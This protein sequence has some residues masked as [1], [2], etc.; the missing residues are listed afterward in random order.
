MSGIRCIRGLSTYAEGESL[1][2][3]PLLLLPSRMHR[4]A[5]PRDY[6][7]GG[8]H[9]VPGFPLAGV[10]LDEA[11]A[12]GYSSPSFFNFDPVARARQRDLTSRVGLRP[13][14]TPGV[15]RSP[16]SYTGSAS[17]V[18]E[19]SIY[20]DVRRQIALDD[21]YS[22]QL[23]GFLRTQESDRLRDV[24]PAKAD[25]KM[26]LVESIQPKLDGR[27]AE[28]NRKYEGLSDEMQMQTQRT[29]QID[30]R[31]LEWRRGLEEEIRA[32]FADIESSHQHISSNA[33]VSHATNEDYVKQLNDRLSRIDRV[34]EEH[35]AFHEVQHGD[36]A[37]IR[38]HLKEMEES[39]V[40]DLTRNDRRHA[41][42]H[43]PAALL[44]VEARVQD[45]WS[46]LQELWREVHD[47]HMRMEAQEERLKALSTKF[48]TTEDQ[49]G[50]L[51][52]REEGFD[53]ESRFTEL[54]SHMSELSQHRREQGERLE[55]VQR[56]LDS[57]SDLHVQSA[58]D[59]H[60]FRE[61]WGAT[62]PGE[63]AM[64]GGITSDARAALSMEMKDCLQRQRASDCRLAS[65]ASDLEA[66]R[67][68][69]ALAPR[70]AALVEQ[71]RE[72]APRVMD[73]E[74]ALRSLQAKAG[75]A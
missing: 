2:P 71:L 13:S 18:Y 14:S 10:S 70:V 3:S 42:G 69:L 61:R 52:Q 11:L 62:P 75:L 65:L 8:S 4:A 43:D 51:N 38:Q 41:P 56:K 46:K 47:N 16:S 39:R 32:K 26:G 15:A 49:Y 23:S 60:S 36:V 24:V 5:S 50:R 74:H 40:H 35:K 28:L 44:A 20:R 22:G 68:D 21:K 57:H 55:H 6:G 1:R 64:A 63:G 12:S 25:P 33:R 17:D 53:W 37:N 31:L 54:S 29:D 67:E 19:S 34:V 59:L 66:V 72:I 45:L 9:Y 27:L 48:E 7:A 30:T 73:H 58:A